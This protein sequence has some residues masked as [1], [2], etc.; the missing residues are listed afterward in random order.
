MESGALVSVAAEEENASACLFS[1]ARAETSTTYP[2]CPVASS[3]KLRW[4]AVKAQRSVKLWSTLVAF[5]QAYGGLG[6][7][8]IV[9]G[10]GARSA[11][12]IDRASRR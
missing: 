7:D 1:N 9:C 6:D 11:S 4:L 5:G 12:L 10:E 2:F 8:V 3:R